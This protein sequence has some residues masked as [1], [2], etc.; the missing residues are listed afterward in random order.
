MKTFLSR[1]HRLVFLTAWFL[2]N[3]W[4][5]FSTG[6]LDDEAYYWVYSQYPA[7]GYYD[8]PPMISWLIQAGNA[9]FSGELGVRFFIVLLNT[10][11]IFLLSELMPK[12]KETAFYAV[13]AS[14]MVAQIGG[15]L[16]V[17]DL[18]LLFFASLY[19]Y[20]YK[21]YIEKPSAI[22]TI[23]FAV[24]IALLMYSKYHGILLV[25]FTLLSNKKLL[26][27]YKTYLVAAMALLLFLPHL[28]WQYNNDF[29][30]VQYHLFERNAPAYQFAFTT[31]YLL[32]QLALAGPLTGWLLLYAAFKQKPAGQ[33][34]KAMKYSMVGVLIFFLITTLRGRVE[35]NWTVPAFI[36]LIVLSTAYLSVK[37]RLLKWLHYSLPITL[38]LVLAVRIFMALDL[39][40]NP[41]VPKDEIHGNEEWTAEV[42]QAAKGLPVVFLDSYQKPSKYYF[43]QQEPSFGLNTI[44]YRRN[45]YNFWPM[46]DSLIG[47]EVFVVGKKND[48]FKETFTHFHLNTKLGAAVIHNY[49]SF[50]KVQLREASAIQLRE[51][52]FELKFTV[53]ASEYQKH[54]FDRP[55]YDTAGIHLAIVKENH[56]PLIFPTSL[57]L[58]DLKD[59]ESVTTTI[60]LPLPIGK[61]TGKLT[62]ST[63]IAGFP[64]LNSTIIKIEKK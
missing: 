2:I 8:H 29:P 36:G 10:L 42:K 49:F 14:L 62:I 21:V 35:A 48:L 17:P 53:H 9:L 26:L 46:E 54:F 52:E 1:H 41:S 44:Y 60:R 51:N 11:T 27:Q 63:A 24:S 39:P 31:E 58:K 56:E 28:L 23:L 33:A 64:T 47:K 19:F 30:S 34:E 16:A 61:H 50:S 43:Y 45:N 12:G 18:P 57:R 13:C 59:T 38:L 5:A 7:W 40:R 22:S 15:I 6:L 4:Q 25:F 37:P 20:M 55:P 3:C 32:G